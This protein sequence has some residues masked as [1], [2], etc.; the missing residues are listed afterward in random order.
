MSDSSNSVMKKA[1][2]GT[3]AARALAGCFPG[4]VAQGVK[5]SKRWIGIVISMIVFILLVLLVI[6][7]LPLLLIQSLVPNPGGNADAL[8]SC[9]HIE[10]AELGNTRDG[11]HDEAQ[12]WLEGSISDFLGGDNEGK[13]VSQNMDLHI[14]EQEVL[15]L[16]SVK[17]GGTGMGE[18]I[19]RDKIREITRMFI[20]KSNSIST[21]EDGHSTLD[22]S[23]T[24]QSFYAVMDELQLDKTQ[25][26]IALN[27]FDVLH[28]NQNLTHAEGNDRRGSDIGDITFTDCQVPIVYY[29]QLDK[30]WCNEPYGKTG[31]IGS[32]ACGPAAL[33]M[34]VSSLTNRNINP[35]E[36][37][38]WAYERGYRAEGNGSYHNLIYEGAASFGLRVAFA[39]HGDGEKIITALQSGKLVAVIMGPG[40]FT[41]SGHFILLRGLTSDGGV[42]VADPA[43][44]SRSEKTW[45]LSIILNEASKNTASP[46]WILSN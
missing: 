39:K 7:C 41:K 36:M 17:Y 5:R 14:N 34:A 18:Q 31:T 12:L 32:S 37:A 22:I 1:R 28:F 44:V 6:V 20:N 4:L 40:V 24:T 42:L 13:N 11:V 21:D 43:S 35:S 15:I 27:M 25:R 46:F 23:V 38:K 26:V 3:A 10:L 19:D 29:N 45:D 2:L 33:A 8:I 30:R 9:A 16:Y